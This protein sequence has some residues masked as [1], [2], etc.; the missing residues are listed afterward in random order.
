MPLM[1]WTDKMSVGVK[2][3]DDDHKKLVTLINDLHE[4][5]KA[6]HGKETLGKILDGLVNYTKSHFEREERL[7]AKT[8]YPDSHAHKKQHDDLTHQVL[9]VQAQYKGGAAATLTMDVMDFLKTWLTNHIQGSDQKYSAHLNA[10]GV[11]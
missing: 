9:S 7:F 3:L 6:G 10:H 4:G 2:V 11:H 1:T 5:L 8:G